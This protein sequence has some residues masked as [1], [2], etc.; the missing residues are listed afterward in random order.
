MAPEQLRGARCRRAQR[1]LRLRRDALRDAHRD[2]GL[3][4]R[5]G[6]ATRSPRSSSTSRRR[7]RPR[8]RSRP[9][10]LERLVAT[11]LAKDPDERWQTAKDLLRELRW[12]QGGSWRL[13]RRRR[14]LS[15][16]ISRG[17]HRVAAAMAVAVLG[18]GGRRRHAGR[19]LPRRPASASS[20][21][22]R[23]HPVPA[24]HGRHGGVARRQPP[25]VRRP[26][27][28]RYARALAAALRCR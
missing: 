19:A 22:R 1:P 26:V 8:A 5:I 20:S 27:G 4:C 11:C 6:G 18:I 14:R 28:R 25:R 2:A 16:R 24:R 23:R 9:P 10:A 3:R 13:T 15:A 7:C 12:V 21:L 17:W